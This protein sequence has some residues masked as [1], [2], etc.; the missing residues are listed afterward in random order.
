MITNVKLQCFRK[1]EDATIQFTEGLQI[2]KAMNE[3]G[4]SSVCEGISYALYGSSVLRTP[5]EEAV[6]WGHDPKELKVEVKFGDYI[7]QRSKNGAQVVLNDKPFVVGQKECSA[8]AAQL[9]G[10]DAHTA[11]LLMFAT[12]GSLRGVLN[13]GPK[14]TGELLE[15]VAGLDVFDRLLEAAGER[16]TLGSAAAVQARISTLEDQRSRIVPV[17]EPDQAEHAA[18]V[19][20]LTK[21]YDALAKDSEV[22]ANISNTESLA[23]S[24]E[25][26]KREDAA[27]RDAELSKLR[28]RIDTHRTEMETISVPPH[29]DTATL[30][31]ALAEAKDFEARVES[32]TIFKTIPLVDGQSREIFTLTRQATVDAL[33]SVASDITQID[34]ALAVLKS[35]LV[36][37][38]L[39]GYCGQDISQFP[40]AAAK[41][42]QIAKDIDSNEINLA[43]ARHNHEQLL[44]ASAEMQRI[45]EQDDA[46]AAKVAK[47][48]AH[49]RVTD[50][51]IPRIVQW[52]GGDVAAGPDA[53]SI[54]GELKAVQAANLKAIQLEAKRNALKDMLGTLQREYDTAAAVRIDTMSPSDYQALMTRLNE[55]NAQLSV[56]RNRMDDL[57]AQYKT[58]TAAFD[59]AKTD[60][61]RYVGSVGSLDTEIATAKAEVEELT[62]NNAL[63]KK[64]RSA[65]PTVTTKLW[66]MVLS[67]VSALFSQVRG[68]KSVVERHAKGFTVNGQA[69]ESL[70]GSTLDILGLAVRVALT[71]TFIPACPFI[72]LDEA[73]A[74]SDAARTESVLGFLASTGFKQIILVTHD[75]ISENF[76]DNI[77][78]L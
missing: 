75:P 54:V 30:E 57:S 53:E 63:V 27:A 43:L 42:A 18:I 55:A 19:A 29:Q 33:R 36:T 58:V 51:V 72:V 41:N 47:I 23:Y 65:R 60:Y 2:I 13:A 22:Y 44:S 12:Q 14:G 38:S 78:Q 7:F 45:V 46:I 52:M 68:E 1:H 8:F 4:K 71:K 56:V 9:I 5:L 21:E 20:V 70:S 77:I 28:T 66:N 3:G 34:K 59:Q 15:S 26:R 61:V 6:T 76:A 25:L 74:A 16:L 64:L 50:S 73:C 40:E 10:A 37:S 32:Y 62:F 31:Q 49:V 39:C 69:V 24:Q 67:S 35:Q 48:R 11:D 17:A